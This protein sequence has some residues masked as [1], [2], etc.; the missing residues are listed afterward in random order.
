M[1]ETEATKAKKKAKLAQKKVAKLEE[2]LREAKELVQKVMADA[3]M[4]LQQYKI[5][6]DDLTIL[7]HPTKADEKWELGQGAFGAGYKGM[8]Q[9]T[10]VVAIKTVRTTKVTTK[11]MEEFRSEI[12]IMAP[13]DHPNLVCMLGA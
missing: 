6:Y 9:G 2:K 12:E 4:N 3:G 7:D 10:A 8:F 13:L 11:V 1:G 5:L